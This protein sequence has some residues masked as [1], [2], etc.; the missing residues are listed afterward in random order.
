MH[1]DRVGV[2]ALR[3][4]QGK[5]RQLPQLQPSEAHLSISNESLGAISWALGCWVD[6]LGGNLGACLSGLSVCPFVHLSQLF[7]SLSS[8]SFLLSIFL[9]LLLLL[10]SSLAS[11]AHPSF[12]STLGATA[13][14]PCRPSCAKHIRCFTARLLSQ[15]R[16]SLGLGPPHKAYPHPGR[17]AGP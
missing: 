12:P 6:G 9:S 13:R 4:W 15:H 16:V 17:S 3:L 2:L 14:S 10:P 1:S 7:S 8:L 5:A 11:S